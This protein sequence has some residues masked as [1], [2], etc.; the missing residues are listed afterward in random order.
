MNEQRIIAWLLE[1]DDSI[2]YQVY[3]DLLG[4]DRKDLQN[5]IANKGWESNSCQ[6]D[7]KKLTEIN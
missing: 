5:N 1:G 3:R 4:D 7:I 2:Q 6:N